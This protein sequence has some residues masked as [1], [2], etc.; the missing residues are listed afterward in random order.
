MAIGLQPPGDYS[1]PASTSSTSENCPQLSSMNNLRS[2]LT[3]PLDKM[4]IP[5]YTA[6][7]SQAEVQASGQVLFQRFVHVELENE[8]L[9]DVLNV[10]ESAGEYEDIAPNLY[11]PVNRRRAA[12]PLF[13]STPEGYKNAHLLEIGANI[14]EFANE[15]NRSRE[16]QR[17]REQAD[18]VDL[19]HINENTFFRM[20]EEVF[21]D[22]INKHCLVALFF[23]CSDVLIRCLKRKMTQLG[24]ELFLWS[25][26]FVVE[27]VCKWVY[28]HGG[29]AKVMKSFWTGFKEVTA[30]TCAV[31][32]IICG[33]V[34]VRKNL[35]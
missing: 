5:I 32:V 12:S 15:F 27:R 9:S 3:L 16:R 10:E 33:I 31:V 17:I 8:G 22:G 7:P 35:F 20:L 11:S 4:A 14:R 13:A 18:Q 26:Q 29:W 30:W 2:T 21:K 34:Y 1:Q 24:T 6:S 28:E 23:F 25:T 19:G